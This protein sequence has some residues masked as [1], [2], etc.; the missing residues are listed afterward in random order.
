MSPAAYIWLHRDQPATAIALRKA[1][2]A[3][4]SMADIA[5]QV[6]ALQKI[7][8]KAPSWYREG[9]VLP[10][11]LPL[12][13]C[14]SEATARFK[15]GLLSG[16]RLLDLTGGLGVDTFCWAGAFASVDCV[17]QQAE[18]CA[19]AR[20]NFELLGRHNVTCHHCT[21]EE[22]LAQAGDARYDLIYLDP[23][24]RDAHQ[25]RV[26]R[27]SDCNPDVVA[28]KQTLFR[29]SDRVLVKTAPMLD[30]QL[31]LGQ[32]EQV[33]QVWVVALGDECKEV[34]YLLDKNISLPPEKTPI[35]A[36]QI[37]KAGQTGALEFTIEAERSAVAP[38]SAPLQYL[39]EP[40]AAILKAGAFKSFAVQYGLA[41]LHPHS[42]LYTAAGRREGVPGRCFEVLGVCKYDKKAVGAL[43]PEGCAN[44]A[45]R[46]F[47]DTP[48]NIRKRLG[49]K[50]GGDTYLFATTDPAEQK[51]MVVCRKHT[52]LSSPN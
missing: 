45:A 24:R 13:Q 2:V 17:E 41:K 31:A 22:F 47:P 42:H 18:L 46:N 3:G 5:R 20:H 50:A 23:A 51:I 35:A 19:A 6:E 4:W 14:S 34:L 28:L 36:V 7:K 27:L 25:Q 44:I 11:G 26:F 32:L 48:D 12:E 8:G 16:G 40:N 38:L 15:A 1:P 43:V 49:L 52:S 30:L 37:G 10:P 9:I 39:Y 29:L 33:A 21:A